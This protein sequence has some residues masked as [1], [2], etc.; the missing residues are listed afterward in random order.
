MVMKS[1]A[2]SSSFGFTVHCSKALLYCN[3]EAQIR[4]SEADSG[5]GLNGFKGMEVGEYLACCKEQC[6][7]TR[8]VFHQSGLW[9]R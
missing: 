5:G 8:V 9:H 1:D 4:V 6:G 3:L 2:L 7:E